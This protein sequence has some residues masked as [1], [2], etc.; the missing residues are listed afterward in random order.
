MADSLSWVAR[1][2]L[3]DRGDPTHQ[4]GPR[5]GHSLTAVGQN[6]FLF[7]GVERSAARGSAEMFVLRMGGSGMG[8]ERV[9]RG[10]DAPPGRWRHSASLVRSAEI[11][12]FGG[13][14]SLDERLADVHVFDC[15]SR[16]WTQ[17]PLRPEEAP[18]ARASHSA[19]VFEES[20]VVFGGYGGEGKSRR[21]FNETFVLDCSAWVWRRLL[22]QGPLPAARSSHQAQLVHGR[23]FV[24]GGANA[25]ESLADVWCLDLEGSPTWR[26]LLDTSLARPL[27]AMSSCCVAGTPSAR[28]FLFGGMA[29][30]LREGGVGDLEA[31]L[32]VFDTESERWSSSRVAS[33]PCPRSDAALVTD[34]KNSRL[35]LFGGWAGRWLGDTLS[36]D[37]SRLIGPP[38]VI[39]GLSPSIG[40]ITGGTALEVAGVD[41]VKS[42]E[43][44]VR[45]ASQ[46]KQL[47]VEGAYVSS[48]CI[49]CE[50][51]DFASL[52]NVGSVDVR[53]SIEGDSFTTSFQT[54][55]IFTV[56]SAANTLMFGPGL[57][58]GC[59][60][61]DEVTFVIVARDNMTRNRTHGGDEFKIS[62]LYLPNG[63]IDSSA[64]QVP[65]VSVKDRGDGKYLVRYA[66]RHPGKYLVNAEFMGTFG[67]VPGPIRG[68]G[69]VVEFSEFAS[70]NNNAMAGALMIKALKDDVAYVR[71]YAKDLADRIFVN[72]HDRAMGDEER[73]RLLISVKESLDRIEP[74]REKIQLLIDRSDAV[75]DFL[76][77]QESLVA[78]V[79]PLLRE[80]KRLW[81]RVLGERERVLDELTPLLHA[82]VGKI[83]ADIFAFQSHLEEL[84]QELQSGEFTIFESG[85]EAA[86]ASLDAAD[87][88]LREQRKVMGTI[89]GMAK[90]FDV[91]KD[92]N[93][94]S[95]IMADCTSLLR[96]YSSF[97]ECYR[98]YRSILQSFGV[99]DW[100]AGVAEFSEEIDGILILFR[101]LPKRIKST[102]LYAQVDK[103]IIEFDRT[104]RIVIALH[105]PTMRER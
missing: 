33:A 78:S 71:S 46:R 11:V 23:M 102:D 31:G 38:Y 14:L 70:R 8:W 74:S 94:C 56:T 83:R 65:G 32:Q 98:K 5:W 76:R 53:V 81:A 48:S 37:V 72:L 69:T 15:I 97:W 99:A 18:S 104:L 39:T 4:P 95:G 47:D 25:R 80:G 50:T 64:S 55:E 24:F 45:L 30:E 40:P 73:I 2:P 6:A 17:P 19:C 41:F 43:I 101:R 89:T 77:G 26:R 42:R 105:S 84:L 96:D 87:A 22:V 36:L 62:V 61:K 35:V 3:P 82:D 16:R 103:V 1:T 58:S 29:G 92:T 21:H 51:P 79:D 54:F 49:T 57:I 44:I 63:E 100:A 75:L 13:Q 91:L 28:V 7:G 34:Y 27:W 93:G 52:G 67:G 59:A 85:Y 90:V 20:L 88:V 9:V 66:A 86:V 10:F 12:V 68:S 60:I